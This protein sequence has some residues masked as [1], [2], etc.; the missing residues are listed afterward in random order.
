MIR[1]VELVLP[2]FVALSACI[3]DSPTGSTPDGGSDAPGPNDVRGI[4]VDQFNAPIDGIS[5]RIDDELST[6]S[7]GG[8]FFAPNVRAKYDAYAAVV[9]GDQKSLVGY[10]EL[11]T[12]TPTLRLRRLDV[13]FHKATFTG[14]MVGASSPLSGCVFAYE[15]YSGS[16]PLQSPQFKLAA[17]WYDFAPQVR[18]LVFP[19]TRSSAGYDL[20]DT[21]VTAV[22]GAQA[23]GALTPSQGSGG[24][25]T[26]SG[27]MSLSQ[28][29]LVG[30]DGTECYILGN[31]SIGPIDIPAV[32]SASVRLVFTS[33]LTQ[34]QDVG[35]L[36]KTA[37]VINGADY[38]ALVPPPIAVLTS[39]VQDGSFDEASVASWQG[40]TGSYSVVF[41]A[42]DYQAEI[43]TQRTS[44]SFPDVKIQNDLA[45]PRPRGVDGAL[46]VT[47]TSSRISSD[48]WAVAQPP[49]MLSYSRSTRSVK[50]SP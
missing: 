31:A 14:S 50:S 6:T 33:P 17:N 25:Y 48:E 28:A 36:V 35:Y 29:T 41:F 9:S 32:P 10:L 42:K 5:V 47:S 12:R 18:L 37:T 4:V 44:M 13:P 8:K 15:G 22:P 3:G 11:S 20:I 21:T 40:G 1:R 2:L 46:S 16:F 34:Q 38:G 30:T 19:T 26:W 43:I 45:A 27:T 23:L 49:P 39:P 24:Y 7:N